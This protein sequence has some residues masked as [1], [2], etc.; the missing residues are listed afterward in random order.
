MDG[1]TSDIAIETIDGLGLV[2]PADWDRVAGQAGG[3]SRERNPFVSHGFLSALE[4]SGSSTRATGW[5]PAHVLARDGAGKLVGAAPAWV[6]SHSYGEYVFDHAW[7][8]AFHRAGGRYYPKLQVAVPFTPVTGPRLLV[9]PAS[10]APEAVRAAL[11]HGLAEIANRARCSSVHVTFTEP[12]DQAALVEAGF[13]ERVDRQYHWI[14]RGYATFDDFLADLASRKRKQIR[15]ERRDALAEGIT[16]QRLSGAD[17]T[18]AHWDAFHAF[19]MD[20]GGRKWGT[21]Y[22]TRR[23]FSLL[24][25][26]A[27]KDVVL[28]LASR[29]GRP[30]AGALN[31]AGS[32][33]LYGRNWGAIEHH[34]FLHF[35]V[36]YYQAI[37]HAI[38][39]GLGRV[40]AGAQGEHKLARGYLPAETRSAHLVAHPGLAAAIGDY[41]KR[42]R[43]AVEEMIDELAEM[44]PFR[45]DLSEG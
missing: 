14:N 29:A 6:K 25:E 43:R 3:P 9:D 34:P 11:V 33:A 1:S 42:E 31:L 13:M 21:P 41:L 36:C 32:H 22:L 45:R 7:A 19:Y 35:E 38:E 44:S 5:A 39:H 8:D 23:F 15:R 12:V 16:I 26:R 2:A 30:I 28:V 10:P 27:G 20:T 18:E 4:D 37:D 24:G 40:E 17:I